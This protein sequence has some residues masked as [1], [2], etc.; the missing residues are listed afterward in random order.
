MGACV[1][2]CCQDEG[3]GACERGRRD[4]NETFVGYKDQDPLPE[5]HHDTRPTHRIRPFRFRSHRLH[6]GEDRGGDETETSRVAAI[7]EAAGVLPLLRTRLR[8]NEVVQANFILLLDVMFEERYAAEWWDGF[9]KME[10]QEFEKIARD[11]VE[12]Q[13]RLALLRTIVADAGAP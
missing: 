6:G 12:P 9:A 13:G 4:P 7:G 11:L 2:D 10:R 3:K 8:E 1:H 5:Q